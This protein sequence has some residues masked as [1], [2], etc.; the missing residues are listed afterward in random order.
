MKRSA[1]MLGMLAVAAFAV[2]QAP[3]QPSQPSGGQ[4]GAQQGSAQSGSATT[5]PLGKRPPQAKTQP[6]F[7]AYN[8]AMVNQK[9]PAAMEKAADDF[10]TKFPESEFACCC[11][12]LPCAD[13]R[14]PTTATKWQRWR[15]SC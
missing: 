6:E 1:I 7:D 10:A 11:T 2:A 12:K 9:D 4:A 5:A 8:A 14:T 13:I 3:S 15:R